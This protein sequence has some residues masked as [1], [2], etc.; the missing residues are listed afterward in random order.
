MNHP[1]LWHDPYFAWQ[2]VKRTAGCCERQVLRRYGASPG[3]AGRKGTPRT[4][5][6]NPNENERIE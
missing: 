6:M 2:A 4:V 1:F 3:G 5:S